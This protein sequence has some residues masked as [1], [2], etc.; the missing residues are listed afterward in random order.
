MIF[1]APSGLLQRGA[2]MSKCFPLSV[3]TSWQHSCIRYRKGFGSEGDR[4][5][6]GVRAIERHPS[7]PFGILRWSS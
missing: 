4:P 2:V 6:L 7:V 1:I 3:E 5:R